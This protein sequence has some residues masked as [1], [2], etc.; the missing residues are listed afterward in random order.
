MSEYI[1][2]LMDLVHIKQAIMRDPENALFA[3]K[4]WKPVYTAH[5]DARLLIVASSGQTRT[6]K[7]YSME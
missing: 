6:R 3:K 1:L 5:K 2:P 7:W 4:G